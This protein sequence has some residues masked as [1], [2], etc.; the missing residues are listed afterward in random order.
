MMMMIDTI[1][2]RRVHFAF[3]S[4]VSIALLSGV[5]ANDA[6]DNANDA[7]SRVLRGVDIV[8]SIPL[9][10]PVATTL[11]GLAMF[12]ASE[13][14]YN[15][16]KAER[17]LI[18]KCMDV[19]RVDL[20]NPLHSFG[21]LLR[22]VHAAATSRHDNISSQVVWIGRKSALDFYFPHAFA[23][24]LLND[25]SRGVAYTY[26][27]RVGGKLYRCRVPAHAYHEEHVMGYDDAR[28]YTWYAT[29]F[30]V[31]KSEAELD[32]FAQVNLTG[33]RLMQ[34]PRFVAVS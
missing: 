16:F 20:L 15:P 19:N 10:G 11:A 17:L 4:V 30:K 7:E 23:A 1:V 18:R 24:L 28:R 34:F 9:V 12:V 13:T 25:E 14:L 33:V 32:R 3:A 8:R 22:H 27:I 29:P 26:A 6:A 21:Q 5:I 2:K 31:K